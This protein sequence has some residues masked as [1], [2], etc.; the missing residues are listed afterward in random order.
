MNTGGSSIIT[1]GRA[2]SLGPR[3]E[4]NG[5]IGTLGMGGTTM[6]TGDHRG[7]RRPH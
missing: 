3:T 5:S 1:C 7:A 6:L 2:M 4:S